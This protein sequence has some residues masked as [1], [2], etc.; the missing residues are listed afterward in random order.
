[1]LSIARR[2][3]AENAKIPVLQKTGDPNYKWWDDIVD[4]IDVLAEDFM[5]RA[6]PEMLP[7]IA[8]G[9]AMVDPLLDMFKTER[10]ARLAVEK[11]LAEYEHADPGLGEDKRK[12][13]DT[14]VADDADIKTA[15]FAHLKSG[16]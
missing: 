12:P 9:A 15:V 13:K 14:E 4:G 1:M 8:Y 2:D 16:R 7:K 5:L 11:R 6:T 10:K 3:L